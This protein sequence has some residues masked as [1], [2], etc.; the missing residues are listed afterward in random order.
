VEFR[1]HVHRLCYAIHGIVVFAVTVS[2]IDRLP[3]GGRIGTGS[4]QSV[5]IDP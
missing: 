1:L 3:S 2:R 4:Q 5:S